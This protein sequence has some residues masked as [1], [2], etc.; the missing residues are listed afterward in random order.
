VGQKEQESTVSIEKHK[1]RNKKRYEMTRKSQEPGKI[2]M[3][4]DE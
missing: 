2:V 3:N 4:M 1:R